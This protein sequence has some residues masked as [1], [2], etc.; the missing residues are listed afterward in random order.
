MDGTA[1][2]G[3]RSVIPDGVPPRVGRRVIDSD[4]GDDDTIPVDDVGMGVG[5]FFFL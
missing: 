4:E 1:T 3:A 2:R 5:Y